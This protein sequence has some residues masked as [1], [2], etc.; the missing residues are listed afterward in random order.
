MINVITVPT[1]L[2]IT[3]I[4]PKILDTPILNPNSDFKSDLTCEFNSSFF[5]TKIIDNV[6]PINPATRLPIEKALANKAMIL[7]ESALANTINNIDKIENDDKIQDIITNIRAA[8]RW[9]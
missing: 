1:K 2:N 5:K 4:I 3:P 9:A 6:T 7:F 8:I